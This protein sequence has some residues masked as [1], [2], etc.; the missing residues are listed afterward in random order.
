MYPLNCGKPPWRPLP[1]IGPNKNCP[2]SLCPRTFEYLCFEAKQTQTFPTQAGRQKAS[3]KLKMKT[4][5]TAPA[6]CTNLISLLSDGG[7]LSGGGNGVS[8]I[9]LPPLFS[10]PHVHSEREA[11][12][13]RPLFPIAQEFSSIS[14]IDSPTGLSVIGKD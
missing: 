11:R 3:P 14:R 10:S 7:R 1:G 6:S 4:T 13:S 9:E 12:K 2:L 8:E 5:E